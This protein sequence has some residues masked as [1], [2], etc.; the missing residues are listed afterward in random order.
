MHRELFPRTTGPAFDA[1]APA[2]V[3]ADLVIGQLL[4][5]ARAARLVTQRALDA[6]LPGL[7]A[8]IDRL[9]DAAASKHARSAYEAEITRAIRYVLADNLMSLAASASMPQARAMAT[10]KLREMMRELGQPTAAAVTAGNVAQLAAAGYLADEIK[11]FLDRPSQ[12]AQRIAVPE[13]PPGAPIGQPA[14]DWLRR[15]YG[16]CTEGIR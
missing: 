2:V 1:I 7:D 16:E 12:P 11:R 15:V 10:L 6:T 8:V 14:M 3:A 4:E 5:P 13:A 9:R